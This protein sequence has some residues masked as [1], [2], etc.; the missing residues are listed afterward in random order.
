MTT[1]AAW[2][3]HLDPFAVRLGP[4]MGVRW[5]GLSYIAG[6]A[7][8]FVVMRFLAKRKLIQVPVD[9]VGDAMMLLILGTLIG[10]RVFYVLVYDRSLL[11]FHDAFPFWGVL[12]I[13][14]GGMASHGGMIGVILASWRISRGWTDRRPAS[15]GKSFTTVIVGRTSWLH[16]LD[17]TALVCTFGLFFGRI[18]NFINAELLGKIHSPA[19]IEGPWWTVQFPKEL[20]HSDATLTPAQT[21]ALRDLVAQ[22]PGSTPRSQ[23]AYIVEHADRYSAQLKPLLNSRYPS[24]LFQATAEGIVVGLCLLLIWSRPRKP[25]VIGSW[26]LIIYGMGRIATEFWRLPDAQ[27]ITDQF[28]SGRPYGLSM[29]QWLSALMVAVGFVALA[30]VSRRSVLRLGGWWRPNPRTAA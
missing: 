14:R 8:A 13:N 15:D 28:K 2:F 23:L 26:F 29:G 5:Y 4:D 24:Q 7:A 1:L 22:A 20:L 21:D 19:G 10:G 11:R 16:V 17:I 25:G 3:H 9:R 30:L 12:A 27:F 6:F 18:A